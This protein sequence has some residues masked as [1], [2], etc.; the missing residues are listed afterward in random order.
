MWNR[1]SERAKDSNQQIWTCC[2]DRSKALAKLQV[3][4]HTHTHTHPNENECVYAVAV[5][6][7]ATVNF[8]MIV[9][10]NGKKEKKNWRFFP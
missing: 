3:D 10:E 7:A 9:I 1:E 5:A 4:T 2:Y 6:A 8:R